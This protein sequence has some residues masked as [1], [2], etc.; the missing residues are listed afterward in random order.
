MRHTSFSDALQDL[1]KWYT[2]DPLGVINLDQAR[3]GTKISVC[4]LFNRLPRWGVLRLR[5]AM[6]PTRA[7]E[8]PWTVMKQAIFIE[9]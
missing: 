9:R 2:R 3:N 1:A 5:L 6:N 8:H 7:V 4:K